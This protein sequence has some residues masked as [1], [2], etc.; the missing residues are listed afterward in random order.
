MWREVD[1]K[2][3]IILSLVL[4]LSAAGVAWAGQE[5]Y[6]LVFSNDKELCP[7]ILKLINDDLRSY[8]EIRYDDYEMFT[9][10]K[11]E[12][13]I[14]VAKNSTDKTGVPTLMSS[15]DLNNDGRFE[16]VLKFSGYFKD[17]LLDWIEF[18]EVDLATLSRYDDYEIDKNRAGRFPEEG[19]P[20][21]ATY[22][23]RTPIAGKHGEPL[24]GEGVGGWIVINPFIHKSVTYLA[25]T[26]RGVTGTN[27]SG[28]GFLVGKYKNARELDEVCYFKQIR[29]TKKGAR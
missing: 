15:L 17:R 28:E 4:M 21:L 13:L 10:I 3:I 19:S 27:S 1:M 5:A 16:I 20:P 24:S 25:I 23:V 14:D 7:A 8:G 22:M 11:W 26:D 9:T 29:P 18:L 12:P 6:K 2:R